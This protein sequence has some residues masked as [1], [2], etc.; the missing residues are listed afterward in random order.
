MARW[1]AEANALYLQALDIPR[2]EERQVF[3]DQACGTDDE[4][5]A[6]RRRPFRPPF[7][8]RTTAAPLAIAGRPRRMRSGPSGGTAGRLASSRTTA[9]PWLCRGGA[10]GPGRRVR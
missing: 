7:R 9:S 5:A 4:S 2:A 8:R 10:A 1:N 3:L 6:P